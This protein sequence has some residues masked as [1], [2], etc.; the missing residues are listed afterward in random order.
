METVSDFIF[1][2][3]KIT[4]D[5]DCNHE[6]KRCLLLE[7]KAMTNIDSI[8][9]SRDIT[10]PTKINIL[11]PMVFPAV[12]YGCKSWTIKKAEHQR[13]DDFE[14]W[15]W[16]RLLRVPWTAR[17]FNQ[18]ILKEINTEYSFLKGLMLKLLYFGQLMR[19]AKSLEKTLMLGRIESRRRRGRQR[20][21][22]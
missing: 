15:C 17:K 20:A 1:L 16:R 12:M 9:K 11:K 7:R 8:L 3:S 21:K 6:I 2:G 13:I 19:R 10:L 18:S 14:L 4:E 5:G 22:W